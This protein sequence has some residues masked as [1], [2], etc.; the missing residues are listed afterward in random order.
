VLFWIALSLFLLFAVFPVYWMFVTTFKQVNDLYNL[1]NNPLFFHR[2]AV[3]GPGAIP[4]RANELRRMG[5]EHA[6]GRPRR[7]RDHPSRLRP[8]G[9]RAR[10]NALPGSGSLSIGIFLTY[11]VPPTLLFLPLSQLVVGLGLVNNKWALRSSIRPSR[12]RS[13]PGCSSALQECPARDHRGARVDGCSRL[14]AMFRIVLPISVP[15]ILTIVIF[16]FTL[17]MQST[18][19]RSRSC[20]RPTRR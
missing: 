17:V 5:R 7:R 6:G 11:L 10:A 3:A 9:V 8:G 13:A 20:L 12:S 2:P 18:S 4:V 14:G 1:E 19:T 15:G 16:A